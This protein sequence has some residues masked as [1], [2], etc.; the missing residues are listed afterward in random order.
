MS[1]SGLNGI[2]SLWVWSRQGQK[3]GISSRCVEDA[4]SPSFG[5]PGQGVSAVYP[6][7]FS[8]HRHVCCD[9]RKVGNHMTV[10]LAWLGF[11]SLLP[12]IIE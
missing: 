9:L 10:L 6:R 12:D 3:P 8:I 1:C 7:V 4:G 11:I 5:A 2:L